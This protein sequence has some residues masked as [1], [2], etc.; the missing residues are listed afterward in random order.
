MHLTGLY[1]HRKQPQ[2]KPVNYFHLVC[3]YP[4]F[5]KKER[6]SEGQKQISLHDASKQVANELYSFWVYIG[7]I[8]AKKLSDV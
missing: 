4:Y 8:Y 6:K 7:N 3:T 5:R 2:F 1:N